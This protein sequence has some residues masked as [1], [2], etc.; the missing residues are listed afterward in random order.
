MRLILLAL[1]LAILSPIPAIAQEKVT[2]NIDIGGDG[3]DIISSLLKREIRKFS[4]VQIV[5][6]DQ[7][8]AVFLHGIAMCISTSGC[9]ATSNSSNSGTGSTRPVTGSAS[10]TSL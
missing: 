10:C 7:D 1:Q 4:D 3:A 5:E 9:T 8:P 2:I 6:R